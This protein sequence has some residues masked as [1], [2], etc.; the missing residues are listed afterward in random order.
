MWGGKMSE[1]DHKHDWKR[2]GTVAVQYGATERIYAIHECAGEQCEAWSRTQ[3]MPEQE[4][5]Y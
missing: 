3:L 1:N 2:T 5:E 4:T